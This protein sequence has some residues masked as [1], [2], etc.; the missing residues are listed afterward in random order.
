MHAL[1]LH[2]L[3][4]WQ[5]VYYIVKNRANRAEKLSILSGVS[6]YF[7]PGEMAAVMGPSGSGARMR[8]KLTP[9]ACLQRHAS[10]PFAANCLHEYSCMVN[11]F[12]CCQRP[13]YGREA[14]FSRQ[15]FPSPHM[16]AWRAGCM[17]PTLLPCSD[18]MQARAGMPRRV[19]AGAD[20]CTTRKTQLICPI[21]AVAG[22]STL[23]DLLAGRKTVGERRGDILFSGISPTTAF[24]RRY[25]GIAFIVFIITN[26]VD[27]VLLCSMWLM[28]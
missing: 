7:S 23:L 28:H 6:G 10:P 25:T 27:V 22:K 24:L 12:S 20:P 1:S 3:L 26:S 4:M 17:W 2:A 18:S 15:Y 14:S 9:T 16:W 5:D 8:P 21:L 19:G 13:V 11:Q